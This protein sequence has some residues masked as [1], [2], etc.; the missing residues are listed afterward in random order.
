[1]KRK[2]NKENANQPRLWL[3]DKPKRKV[4]TNVIYQGDN[5]P[6]LKEL[7]SGKIDLIYIDPPFCSQAVQTSKAWNKKIMSFNDEWGG[8]ISSYMHWLTP[9]LR[10]CHRLLS[11][12]GVFCLHLDHR[13]VHYAKVELDKIFGKNRF[14]NEITWVRDAVGKGAK[15]HQNNI[16]ERLTIF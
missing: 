5:L 3:G 1:M 10:E 11:S 12:A 16:Q 14:L 7:E 15:K 8:G 6:L 13:S 4:K 2:Y 9:R